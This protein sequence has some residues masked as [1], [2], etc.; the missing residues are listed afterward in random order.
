MGGGRGNGQSAPH[1]RG[2]G[3]RSLTR[4]ECARLP[5]PAGGAAIAASF[6]M[7]TVTSTLKETTTETAVVRA[8]ETVPKAADRPAAGSGSSLSTGGIIGVVVTLLAAL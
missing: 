6:S 4:G 2:C 3:R 1:L 8:T 5:T 7:A